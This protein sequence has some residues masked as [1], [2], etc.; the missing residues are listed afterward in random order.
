MLVVVSTPCT[1]ADYATCTKES[2]K[3]IYVHFACSGHC[4][5]CLTCDLR[6]PR[7]VL[8]ADVD[9][10]LRVMDA[11]NASVEGDRKRRGR[12]AGDEEDEVY[13]QSLIEEEVY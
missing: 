4:P 12:R 7:L 11:S 13:L 5:S 10:A 2:G 9:V 1:I 3:R 8:K 6:L